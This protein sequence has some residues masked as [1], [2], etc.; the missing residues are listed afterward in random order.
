MIGSAAV[1]WIRSSLVPVSGGIAKLIVATPDAPF[2][3]ISA[4]RRL[5]CAAL[6]R[7]SATSSVVLTTSGGGS[8]GK[9]AENSDVPTPVRVAVVVITVP[10]GN[11]SLVVSVPVK[12]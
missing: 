12:P 5:Q 8:S 2:A 3:T 9:H 10:G 11:G 1:G 7:P 4:S 6:Q